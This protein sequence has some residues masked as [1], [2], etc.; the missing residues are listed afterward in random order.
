MKNNNSMDLARLASVLD[1]ARI[2]RSHVAIVGVGGG[3]DFG[4]KLCR[5]GVQR[6]TV[7]DNQRVEAVNIPRQHHDSREIGELKVDSFAR[8]LERI[9]PAVEVVRYTDDFSLLSD[10]VLCERLS[11]CNLLILATDQFRAQARGNRVALRLRLPT[12][13]LGLYSLGRAGELIFW[14]EGIDA[15]YRCLCAKRYEL[16]AEAEHDGRTIDP[17]SDGCT[18]FDVAHI[19]AIAGD[20][21]LGLLNRGCD[22]RFGN[23]VET[24]GDRNFIHV[25]RDPHWQVNGKNP[26]RTYLQVPDSCEAFVTWNV[27]SRRDPD[28]GRLFCEDCSDLRGDLFTEMHKIPVRLRMDGRSP[29][30]SPEA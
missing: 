14:H 21:A 4:A 26:V 7:F 11:G 12:M 1:V 8:G 3:A 30:R 16:H 18:V 2:Q 15:C 29:T 25:Q 9:N 24:L 13:W 10:E 22:N 20:V 17:P 6:F 23:L 28:G 19:D 27:V 5:C